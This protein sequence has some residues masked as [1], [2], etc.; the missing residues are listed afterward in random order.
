MALVLSQQGFQWGRPGTGSMEED[1]E[2]E[3]IKVSLVLRIV[4]ADLQDG[5]TEENLKSE[6]TRVDL[7]LGPQGPAQCWGV[8][9]RTRTLLKPRVT[10]DCPKGW[11]H[12]YQPGA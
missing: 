9:K 11:V 2:P 8:L 6:Y 3:S 4:G 7:V 5:S 12:G 1:M 10:E